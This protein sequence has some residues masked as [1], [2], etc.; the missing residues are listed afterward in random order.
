MA[1]RRQASNRILIGDKE[2]DR[3]L[4][5]MKVGTANRIGRAGLTKGARLGAKIAKSLV[6]SR[7]KS[8]KRSIGHS[9]KTQKRGPEKGNVI[10]K[11]GASVGRASKNL[12]DNGNR[13][14]VGMSARNLHWFILG[15]ADR[16]T[17]AGFSR[18]AMPANPII[19]RATQ[20]GMGQIKSAILEGARK[21]MDREEQ[22]LA[23]KGR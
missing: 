20:M 21:Q 5:G 11:F 10:A 18:G 16:Y 3:K 7:H 13:P 17:K 15:T 22:K 1:P 9:V 19:K 14:G 2:L 23:K 6:E 8:V 4:Q 12:K